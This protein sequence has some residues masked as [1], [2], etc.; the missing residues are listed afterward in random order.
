[1][2]LE[3]RMVTVREVP[4]ALIFVN[5]LDESQEAKQHMIVESVF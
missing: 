4:N 2:A 3:L 1:M 5:F